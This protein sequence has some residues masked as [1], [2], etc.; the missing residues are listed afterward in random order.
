MIKVRWFLCVFFALAVCFQ[1]G[2]GQKGEG[3][4]RKKFPKLLAL[5]Y[6][7]EA[8][9][10]PSFIITEDFDKDGF[11]DLAVTNSGEH[12]FSI[13]KGAKGGSFGKP[14][15]YKTGADPICIATADFNR[16][17]YPDLAE[18]NYRDQ[19]IQIFLNTRIGGFRNTGNV[20]EPGRIPINIATGDFNED[21]FPD[22]AVSMRYHK[23]ILMMGKGDGTFK[24]SVTLPAKGQP[25]GVVVG[26][27]NKDDHLDIAFAV[28]GS[29]RTGVQ[30]YWGKG[31]GEFESSGPF[32]GGGQPLSIANIDANGDGYLDLVT[33]SNSLHAV[34][35]LLNNKDKT[36][37]TLQDFASGE[38][39][40]FVAVGDFSGDGI[41]DLAVSN[42]T[43]DYVTISLG[44]GDGY[45][46]YPPI[47]HPTDE[48][49]Q[50]MAVG[51]FNKDGR[52][53]IAVSTRDKNLIDI[54]LSKNTAPISPLSGKPKPAE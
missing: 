1:I 51:D 46:T 8:G 39:P 36:F 22:L 11:L 38:F 17:G 4:K 50:G 28:A 40:K 48:Y 49:P 27:Y 9:K 42:A 34:T 43:S 52:P 20:I 6:V 5:N 31:K 18:L 23:I 14:T 33:S 26:D 35:Q 10:E 25:T 30:V 19:N 32:K 53:D 41:P 44:Y 13:F 15:V 3:K 47:I 16:D 24:E 21:E 2:C 45:F 12:T 37:T 29:G 7:L 54:L